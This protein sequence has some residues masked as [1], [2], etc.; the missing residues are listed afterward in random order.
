M[1]TAQPFGSAIFWGAQFCVFGVFH[2]VLG[3]KLVGR[4]LIDSWLRRMRMIE[5]LMLLQVH[6]RV[7]VQCTAVSVG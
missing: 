7:M 3:L 6:F 1:S 4:L 2:E 5:D